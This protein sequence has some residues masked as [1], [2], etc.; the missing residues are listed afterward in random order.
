M[1]RPKK[2]GQP[3]TM[4]LRLEQ[5]TLDMLDAR[6]G[7]GE[8]R[9]DKARQLL[10]DGLGTDPGEYERLRAEISE[11]RHV[12]ATMGARNERLLDANER[13]VRRTRWHP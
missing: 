4:T 8:S 9:S 13:L 11:L 5:F 6:R 1:P 7:V 2:F 10:T 12:I 3:A